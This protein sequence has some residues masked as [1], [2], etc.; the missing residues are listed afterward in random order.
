MITI[1]YDIKNLIC[2][3]HKTGIAKYKSSGGVVVWHCNVCIP[4]KQF[5]FIEVDINT[6]LGV[7]SSQEL[8]TE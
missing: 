5:G 3:I 2:T 8:A 4:L 6:P 1:H 7:F